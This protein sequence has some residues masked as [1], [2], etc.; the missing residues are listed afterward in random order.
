MRRNLIFA[1]LFGGLIA[2]GLAS[3]ARADVIFNNFGPGD[4]FSVAGRLLQGEAVGTIGNVDQAV[5]FTVGG[6]PYRLTS[7]ALGLNV[8]AGGPL[9]VLIAQDAGGSPGA[10]LRTASLNLN[11][12][13][14][15]VVTAPYDGSLVLNAGATYWVIADAKGTL[16]GGWNFNS[17][18]DVGLTAG[19][20]DNGPWNLRPN[21]DRMALRVEGRLVPE[22]SSIVLLGAGLLGLVGYGWRRR[23]PA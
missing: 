22:P 6:G 20:S 4:S 8:K 3:A 14:P 9:D 11:P 19:R 2:L 18:G 17:V 7:A 13:D 10:V 21:D 16:D 15:Q 23:R 5:S 1:L 12:G